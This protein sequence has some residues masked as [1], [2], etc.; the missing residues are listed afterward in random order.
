M[1]K[2]ILAAIL[3][4]IPFTIYAPETSTDD[5]VIVVES[6]PISTEKLYSTEQSPY[7][8]VKDWGKYKVINLNNALWIPTFFKRKHEAEKYADD[9]NIS[10]AK[11]YIYM[12][13]Q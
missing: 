3:C 4:V 7:I 8:V 6:I 5:E 13:A 11:E 1:K 2:Y 10:Y 9:M 12:V